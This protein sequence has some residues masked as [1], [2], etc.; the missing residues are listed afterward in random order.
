MH[1]SSKEVSSF[2]NYL[3]PVT[4]EYHS[5][6]N[7][8][9]LTGVS[10]L[11]H[12]SMCP[13][14]QVRDGLVP[15]LWFFRKHPVPGKFSGKLLIHQKYVD[16]VPTKWRSRVG[17]YEIE[18]LDTIKSRQ[19]KKLLLAGL[20][21]E[22]CCSLEFL[23]ERLLELCRE[24]T[25]N[26]LS[27]MEIKALLLGRSDQFGDEHKHEYYGNFCKKIFMKLGLNIQFINWRI[28][29]GMESLAGYEILEFNEGLLCADSFMTFNAL[30][31]GHPFKT[32]KSP[33]SSG[34]VGRLVE[35]SPYHGMRVRD[36]V[37]SRPVAK[38]T[39]DLSGLNRAMFSEA[40]R[41]L[42]WPVWFGIWARDQ[43][44][45]GKL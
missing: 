7:P 23:E 17:S 24:Y 26:E 27:K 34:G 11:G 31:R 44:S 19:P 8:I 42:P 40:N 33:E 10:D 16:Y 4:V 38:F 20:V 14:Y 37:S 28:F 41:K 3:W 35:L 12:L 5:P 36:R 15:L 13:V 9:F 2:L 6:L 25:A 30:S 1:K 22:S 18:S 21:M 39:D 32:R 29:H 43:I 45:T